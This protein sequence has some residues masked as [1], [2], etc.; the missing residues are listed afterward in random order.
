MTLSDEE[1]NKGISSGEFT[2]PQYAREHEQNSEDL[3]TASHDPETQA[4]VKKIEAISASWTSGGLIV[5][6]VT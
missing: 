3:Q 1:K 5:A 6:Y 4:G 2:D